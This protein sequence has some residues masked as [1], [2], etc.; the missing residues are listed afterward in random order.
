VELNRPSEGNLLFVV[1]L[2][3]DKVSRNSADSRDIAPWFISGMGR[4]Y[5]SDQRTFGH[6]YGHI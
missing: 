1:N 3:H 4:Y 2:K 5:E 6:H